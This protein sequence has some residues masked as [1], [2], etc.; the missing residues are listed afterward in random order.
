MIKV[1]LVMM[2]FMSACSVFRTETYQ[3]KAIRQ[4]MKAIFERPQDLV[5]ILNRSAF[6]KE[7]SKNYEKLPTFF[8]RIKGNDGKFEGKEISFDELIKKAK[9]IDVVP[10]EKSIV[11]GVG[12]TWY[13]DYYLFSDEFEGGS[14]LLTISW[15]L[16][17]Y[18]CWS[19]GAISIPF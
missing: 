9:K 15:H 10:D 3:E 11:G 14:V 17:S 13:F 8:L 12:Y 2:L 7:G 6:V 1:I 18:N 16:N 19:F 5:R 4:A